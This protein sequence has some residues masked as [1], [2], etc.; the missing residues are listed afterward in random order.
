MRYREQLLGSNYEQLVVDHHSAPMR[1]QE[2]PYD[3]SGSNEYA[4]CNVDNILVKIL[5]LA[6]T[7]LRFNCAQK[8]LFSTASN[9]DIMKSHESHQ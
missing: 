5:P 7:S 8:I 4:L 1:V 6:N 3:P 9:W 2:N